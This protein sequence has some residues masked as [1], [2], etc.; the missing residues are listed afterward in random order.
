MSLMN[1]YSKLEEQKTSI[2]FS[3]PPTPAKFEALVEAA[4]EQFGLTEDN[5]PEKRLGHVAFYAFNGTGNITIQRSGKVALTGS[6]MA[7]ESDL[8]PADAR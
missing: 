2:N 7:L 4:T 6:M 1:A 8:I 5:L 3:V